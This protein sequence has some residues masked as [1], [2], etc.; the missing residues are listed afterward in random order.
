MADGWAIVDQRGTERLGPAGRFEDV[1][2]VSIRTDRGTTK[3]FTIP[4]GMYSVTYVKNLVDE[5][6]TRSNQIHDL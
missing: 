1:V 5:W 4:D 2:E 6:V 3:T